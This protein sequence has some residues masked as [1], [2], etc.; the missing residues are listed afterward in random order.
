MSG[1]NLGATAAGYISGTGQQFVGSGILGQQASI[2]QQPPNLDP[3]SF[4]ASPIDVPTMIAQKGYNPATFDTRP[5]FVS[6][7]TLE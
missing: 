3:I 2:A 1:G 6:P 7:S 4:L 5:D